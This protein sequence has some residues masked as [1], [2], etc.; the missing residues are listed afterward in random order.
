[1]HS[2]GLKYTEANQTMAGTLLNLM[3]QLQKMLRY[4]SRAFEHIKDIKRSDLTQKQDVYQV[5]M[6][7]YMYRFQYTYRITL[8]VWSLN[9]IQI[10]IH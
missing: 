8:S 10:E 5:Q 3:L 9:L 1:M 2:S 4:H 6:L 7:F